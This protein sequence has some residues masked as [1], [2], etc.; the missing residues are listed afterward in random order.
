MI[1]AA[2]P[3]N[4]KS[5]LLTIELNSGIVVYTNIAVTK[6]GVWLQASRG[7]WMGKSA[8]TGTD[9]TQGLME[10]KVRAEQQTP[11]D[12]NPLITGYYTQD[13]NA[14]WN[15]NGRILLRQID[16]VPLNVLAVIPL[17]Y[18]PDSN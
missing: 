17:G 14:A 9:A 11:A 10:L 13:I 3:A 12:Q 16:P 8:P 18:L 5:L 15:S 4:G 7:C 2:R 1:Y 6:V